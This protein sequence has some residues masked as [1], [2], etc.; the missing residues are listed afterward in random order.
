MRAIV[1]QITS[2]LAAT[3]CA[4]ERFYLTRHSYPT[5]L[6]ELVP[7]IANAITIDRANGKPLNY[8]WTP[9][10]WFRLWSVGRDVNDDGGVFRRGE[11]ERGSDLVWP[12]PI[13]DGEDR[14]F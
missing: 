6:A 7:E 5:T 2:D 11:D 10:G 9:D 14:L 12:R 8:R 13:A 3:A 4:L 1:H